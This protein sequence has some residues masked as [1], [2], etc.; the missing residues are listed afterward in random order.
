MWHLASLDAPTVAVVWSLAFAWAV[1]AQLS[2]RVLLVLALTVWCAYVCDRLLDARSG[3][4]SP[5]G[6]TQS[7]LLERHFFHWRHRRLLAPLAVVAACVAGAAA[8]TLLQTFVRERGLVLAAAAMVYFSGVHA[9]PR[10]RNRRL[11]HSWPVSKE[12]PVA[13]LFTAGCIL[14][15]WSR[16]HA[17]GARDFSRWWFWFP[18]VYFAGLAWLN[19][20]SIARWECSDE[21]SSNR[22]DRE[23]RTYSEHTRQRTNLFAALLVA[24]AGTLL[25]AIASASHPRAGALIAAGA[26]SALLL[27][28]VD[29]MRTRLTPLALRAAAD[30][31]LLTPILLFLR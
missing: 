25:A 5:R 15:A 31:V 16:L 2:G 6:A 18:A 12:L 8:V 14:P 27:A 29:C 19:C 26:A 20:S 23:G 1:G 24:L 21:H 17:S 10:V 11:A 30:L 22:F 9:A 13:V 7:G 28:L 4:H 3:L